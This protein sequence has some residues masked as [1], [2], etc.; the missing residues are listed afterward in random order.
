MLTQ[1][2][3]FYW[4]IENSERKMKDKHG[5]VVISTVYSLP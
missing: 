4:E 5:H 3:Q 2:T 1:A